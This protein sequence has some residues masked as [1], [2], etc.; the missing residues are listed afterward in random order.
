MAAPCLRPRQRRRLRA[1]GL[2]TVFFRETAFGILLRAAPFAIFP[3]VFFLAPGAFGRLFVPLRAVFND[4][5]PF[6]FVA[7]RL[8]RSGVAPPAAP[9]SSELQS[10]FLRDRRPMGSG[11]PAKRHRSRYLISFSSYAGCHQGVAWPCLPGYHK[12]SGSASVAD[13]ILSRNE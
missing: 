13:I 11:T 3:A 2:R 10:T 12:V 6:L 1:S 7:R 9:P 8:V 5:E 4:R